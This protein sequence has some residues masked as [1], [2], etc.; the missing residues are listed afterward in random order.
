MPRRLVPRAG[1]DDK[2]YEQ[3][4]KEIES[5]DIWDSE[6]SSVVIKILIIAASIG[7][8]VLLV[9]AAQPVITNTINSF[10]TR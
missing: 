4:K 6:I 9:Y 5:Q 1:E 10:P 3:M 8:V 2:V 7:T